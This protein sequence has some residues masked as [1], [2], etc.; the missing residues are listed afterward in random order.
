MAS[1]RRKES[2]NIYGEVNSASDLRSINRLIRKDMR[3]AKARDQMSEL[4]RRSDYLCTLTRSPAWQT[5][6]G[7]RSDRFLKV[8]KEENHRSVRLANQIAKKQHWDVQYDPW[9]RD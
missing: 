7:E 1:T 4:K 3:Q 9:G 8:A 5:R 2:N 6:F